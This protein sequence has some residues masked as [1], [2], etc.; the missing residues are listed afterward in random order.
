MIGISSPLGIA[1]VI[2]I[3]IGLIM[4]IIGT[5]ILIVNQNK[6]SPWYVWGLVIVGFALAIIGSTLLAIALSQARPECEIDTTCDTC[7]YYYNTLLGPS[8]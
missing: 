7:A 2:L 1:G 3:I 6:S 5:I 8:Y 4:A